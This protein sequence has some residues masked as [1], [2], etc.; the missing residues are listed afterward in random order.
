M[1][2]W[3]NPFKVGKFIDMEFYNK[4]ELNCEDTK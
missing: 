4:S 1:Y 3:H 2:I